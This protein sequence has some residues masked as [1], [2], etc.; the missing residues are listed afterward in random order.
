MKVS[1]EY[2][3]E[4]FPDLIDAAF[5]GEEVEIAVPDKPALI[6]VPRIAGRYGTPSGR[7]RAEFFGSG[8]GLVKPTQ[9]DQAKRPFSEFLGIWEGKVT[10]PTDEEWRAMDKELEDEMLNGPVFPPEHV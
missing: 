8:E 1:A 5:N 10:L 7:P 2:A 6:L 4:H 9:D 3:Q